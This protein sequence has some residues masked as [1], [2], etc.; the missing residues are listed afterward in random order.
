MQ[1]FPALS[2]SS[3]TQVLNCMVRRNSP[4][5]GRAA[6]QGYWLCHLCQPPR[7]GEE[8]SPDDPKFIE[9]APTTLSAKG[10]LEGEDHAGDV[11]PVPDGAEDPVGKSAGRGKVEEPPL[12]LCGARA[13][14]EGSPLSK[15]W[16]NTS[17]GRQ[18]A[19]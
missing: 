13:T 10:L 2:D 3:D 4:R 1:P 17:S 7:K 6:L 12:V 8:L 16:R 18:W 5:Q 9:I 19:R 14:C 11:V 15:F